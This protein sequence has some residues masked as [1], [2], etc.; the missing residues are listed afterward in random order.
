MRISAAYEIYVPAENGA[1]KKLRKTGFY[2]L[3]TRKLV[4][5]NEIIIQNLFDIHETR[6]S[7]GH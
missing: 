6:K 5:F 3:Y 7:R 4:A 2:K 1:V